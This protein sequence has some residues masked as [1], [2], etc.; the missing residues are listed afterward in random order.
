MT[1]R[2]FRELVH[3]F[4]AACDAYVADPGG[5]HCP[6]RLRTHPMRSAPGIWEMTRSFASPDGRAT[7]AFVAVDDETRVRWRC[8]GDHR[9]YREP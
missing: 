7:F 6:A 3:E 9:V 5:G 2:A 1:T 8:I 4:S